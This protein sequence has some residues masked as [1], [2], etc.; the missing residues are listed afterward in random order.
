MFDYSNAISAIKRSDYSE[1]SNIL[2]LASKLMCE[3]GVA[4]LQDVMPEIYDIA[5]KAFERKFFSETALILLFCCHQNFRRDEAIRFLLDGYYHPFEESFKAAYEKN[6]EVFKKYENI[7]RKEFPAF[8]DL[9]YSYLPMDLNAASQSS[10]WLRYDRG[11]RR[12]VIVPP[13]RAQTQILPLNNPENKGKVFIIHETYD[14]FSIA[15]VQRE[16]TQNVNNL[17]IRAHLYLYYDSFEEFLSRLQ[18][19]DFTDITAGGKAFFLFGEK[20]LSEAMLKPENFFVQC[21]YSTSPQAMAHLAQ[22]ILPLLL[23]EKNRRLL[24]QMQEVSE[25]YSKLTPAAIREKIING[26]VRVGLFP[27]CIH[28][29]PTVNF[30]RDCFAS[31]KN[32]NVDSELFISSDEFSYM[33]GINQYEFINF[34]HAFRPDILITPNRFRWMFPNIPGQLVFCCWLQDSHAVLFD[35]ESVR[36]LASLDFMLVHYTYDAIRHVGYKE[37]RYIHFPVLSNKHLYK[38]YDLSPEEYN[39]YSADV[40]VVSNTGNSLATLAANYL[41]VNNNKPMTDKLRL[42]YDEIYKKIYDDVYMERRHYVA[43][44]EVKKIFSEHFQRERINIDHAQFAHQFWEYV[45]AD[46]YKDVPLIWLHE[47]GYNLKLWGKVWPDHPVLKRYAK[48]QIK[49]RELMSKV[50]NASKISINLGM[51]SFHPRVLEAVFSGCLAFVHDLPGVE[52]DLFGNI[53][54]YLAPDEEI[55]MMKD[56]KDMYDKIDYYLS[57]EEK[58]REVV[59]KG[60][61]KA[62]ATLTYEA[63]IRRM[64]GEMA[65]KIA[66]S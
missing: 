47:K 3:T 55:I 7:S 64:L 43:E 32:Q 44:Q 19:V 13:L 63:S 45:V 56:K 37:N 40:C 12:F 23:N 1:R 2:E 6:T 4:G 20:E 26:T 36:K 49:S 60:Q 27:L 15:D 16:T 42:I 25:H 65:E 24:K 53:K 8:A 66:V 10:T 59:R 22:K 48:G 11:E 35:R 51:L 30:L 14:R 54:K 62:L 38:K 57:N 33:R 34:L 21:V 41:N 9:K 46:I 28:S 18:I 61:E 5:L 31:L 17:T 58:R 50:L 39:E 29:G 52:S